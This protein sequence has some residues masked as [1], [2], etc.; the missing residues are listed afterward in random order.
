MENNLVFTVGFEKDKRRGIIKAS[1]TPLPPHHFT[2]EAR[3]G[4]YC[5]S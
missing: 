3:C 5:F 4:V 1:K 2:G